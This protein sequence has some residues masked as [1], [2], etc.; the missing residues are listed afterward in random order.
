[1][2]C[3]GCRRGSDLVLLWLWHGPATVAVIG[4]L[5]W[6][7]T[8]AKGVALKKQTEKEKEN[9]KLTPNHLPEAY[10]PICM[11]FWKVPLCHLWGFVYQ[12]IDEHGWQRKQLA[13]AR[14]EWKNPVASLQCISCFW[15]M[16]TSMCTFI[17]VGSLF[18]PPPTI[19][20]EI[21]SAFFFFFLWLHLQHMEVLR[22]EV[23][24]ELQ[25]PAYTTATVMPDPSHICD[26]SSLQQGWILN[27]LSEDGDQTCI[28]TNTILGS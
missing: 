16:H 3:V 12:C 18:S 24:S 10:W 21:V 7:L 22:P 17:V 23:K 27:L 1:M 14:L 26:L 6:E 5:A 20:Y 19:Y 15:Y 11:Q 28:L 8:N 13:Q 4:P 2:S 9:A 25:L